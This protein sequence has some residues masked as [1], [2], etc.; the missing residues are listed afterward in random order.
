[1]EIEHDFSTLESLVYAPTAN[2]RVFSLLRLLLLYQQDHTYAAVRLI[3]YNQLI[4]SGLLCTHAYVEIVVSDKIKIVVPRQP[5]T[6][7]S[8]LE[9]P[10][11][12]SMNIWTQ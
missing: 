10:S 7:D 9:G 2:D 12:L 3:G 8:D 11:L 5:M 4:F 6:R 1:M